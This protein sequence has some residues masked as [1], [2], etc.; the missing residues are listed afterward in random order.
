MN[1]SR[2]SRNVPQT[3]Q[4]VQ[5]INPNVSGNN[6]KPDSQ[7]NAQTG[8]P[9]NIINHNYFILAKGSEANNQSQQGPSN[10]NRIISK[11]PIYLN[12]EQK[13]NNTQSSNVSSR[14][15]FEQSSATFTLN[16]KEVSQTGGMIVRLQPSV[17]KVVNVRAPQQRTNIS[18]NVM[19]AGNNSSEIQTGRQTGA[20]RPVPTN[21]SVTANSAARQEDNMVPKIMNV[22]SL[23][24][25]MRPN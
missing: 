8:R 21:T 9:T 3:Q 15:N 19:H 1:S 12:R 14:S 25:F 7:A 10:Q 24:N 18:N 23:A 5:T 16:N 11:Q 6:R 22:F 20:F 4:K 2:I 13:T 17:Q